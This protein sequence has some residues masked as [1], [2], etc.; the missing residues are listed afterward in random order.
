MK[1]MDISRILQSNYLTSKFIQTKCPY[2]EPN[3]Q[4][5]CRMPC[6]SVP[7]E[8]ILRRYLSNSDF[9]NQILRRIKYK[10]NDSGTLETFRDIESFKKDFQS[11]LHR[12][13][14]DERRIESSVIYVLI[15]IFIEDFCLLESLSP[16]SS[17]GKSWQ[18]TC[19]LATL[20]SRTR[21]WLDIYT[22]FLEDF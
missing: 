14:H 1:I 10:G 20:N 3:N 5:I 6:S 9:W 17:R 4:I 7:I 16:T 12:H 22:L 2:I 19:P 21:S 11:F 8:H 15:D 13:G 18:R